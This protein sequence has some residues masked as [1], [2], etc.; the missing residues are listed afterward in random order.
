MSTIEEAIQQGKPFKNPYQRALIN[1]LY[2]AAQLGYQNSVL[3]K[4]HNITWQQF[5]L[6]RI[7]KGC[8]PK[9]VTVK[10]IAERMI[11]RSSNASRLVDKLFDKALVSRTNNEKDRRRVNIS[12]TE[13]GMELVNLAS[14]DLENEIINHFANRLT[15]TEAEQLSTLLDKMRG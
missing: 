11:D 12:L 1:I 5:N 8:H 9:P 15:P 7:L 6:L 2:S 10:Y 13:K 3:L 14:I 4:Q